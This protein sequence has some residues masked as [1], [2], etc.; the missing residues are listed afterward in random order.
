MEEDLKNYLEELKEEIRIE[1][2]DHTLTQ[3]AKFYERLADWAY[4][5]QEKSI[6]SPLTL[7]PI[8]YD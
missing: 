3:R 6:T 1:M 2:Q 5:R 7:I 8:S 4:Q